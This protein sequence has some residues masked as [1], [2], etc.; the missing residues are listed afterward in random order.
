MTK[1]PVVRWTDQPARDLD[2]PQWDFCHSI[3]A[4]ST[5]TLLFL[6]TA[7]CHLGQAIYYRKAY[8]W[9]IVS[10]ASWQVLAFVLRIPSI[11]YPTE[12]YWYRCQSILIL[13]R[14]L[15]SPCLAYSISSPRLRC[16]H[17]YLDARRQVLE[18]TCWY[19][20]DV[21]VRSGRKP[22]LVNE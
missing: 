17:G 8:C 11:R 2:N 10:G 21:P 4:V 6:L 13:V 16:S 9:V 14:Y 15:E 22:H 3:V 18:D 20:S 5:L 12:R 1:Y 7:G 19:V